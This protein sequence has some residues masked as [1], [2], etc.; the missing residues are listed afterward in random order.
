MTP[1]QF[2]QQLLSHLKRQ[3]YQPF[4]VVLTSGE[5]FEVDEPSVAHSGAGAAGY[6][7]PTGEVYFFDHENTQE[8]RLPHARA[9][10]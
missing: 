7:G 5:S 3:P 9:T 4:V 6:I 2:Q 8:F 10:P 1:E